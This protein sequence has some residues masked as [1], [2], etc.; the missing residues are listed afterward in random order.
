MRLARPSSNDE[1]VDIGF[2]FTSSDLDYED[3]VH[4]VLEGSGRVAETEGHDA[5]FEKSAGGDEGCFPLVSFLHADVI[6]SSTNV[7]SG[8][9]DATS[10]LVDE[11]FRE[12]EGIDVLDGYIV[13]FTIVDN[14]ASFAVLLGDEEDRSPNA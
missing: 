9:I 8:K 1:V 14:H 2:G 3:V 11:I 6:I 13:E 10:P 7:Q 5:G 12:R 4:H